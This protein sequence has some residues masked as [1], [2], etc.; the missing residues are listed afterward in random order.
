MT[1]CKP[2]LVRNTMTFST[3]PVSVVEHISGYQTGS[4]YVNILNKNIQIGLNEIY[5]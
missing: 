5:T 1:I 3:N 4:D 2:F